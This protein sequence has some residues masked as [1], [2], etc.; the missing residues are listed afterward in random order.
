MFNEIKPRILVID[1]NPVTYKT[2]S[3]ALSSDFN[4]YQTQDIATIS[5][6][7]LQHEIDIVVLSFNHPDILNYVDYVTQIKKSSEVQV[8]LVYGTFDK[9]EKQLSSIIDIS[10]LRPFD[11]DKLKN[12]MKQLLSLTNPKFEIP[13]NKEN[14][15][16]SK[17]SKEVTSWELAIPDVIFEDETNSED[18]LD[19]MLVPGIILEDATM[20]IPKEV[21][22]E[23][24]KV[25]SD[26]IETQ[27]QN[28]KVYPKQND[29]EYPDMLDV[30]NVIIP[31]SAEVEETRT[32][33]TRVS[34][35]SMVKEPVVK[36]NTSGDILGN[37]KD[38]IRS[39][40][41]SD[42]WLPE[43][44]IQEKNNSLDS[45]HFQKKQELQQ[46]L[47]DG[48]SLLKSAELATLRK[49]VLAQLRLDVSSELKL[50]LFKELK[51]SIYLEFEESQKQEIIREIKKTFVKDYLEKLFTSVNKEIKDALLAEVKDHLFEQVKSEVLTSLN[52]SL[53]KLVETTIL[54]SAKAH[55]VNYA[56]KMINEDLMQIRTSI[57]SEQ[58]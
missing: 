27:M 31:K 5:N 44:H 20:I 3:E 53:E 23:K 43:E 41:E 34:M 49:E 52:K 13:M 56:E 18:L 24:A 11:L 8:V 57:D 36:K 26:P 16:M 25:E 51:K 48:D 32:D 4:I 12:Q 33:V 58:Y 40:V 42:Q 47:L 50:E 6:Y 45:V 37:L 22:V 39:E 35:K 21:M 7:I 54:P 38:K 29:L 10:I 14:D 17:L 46:P 2:L 9:I 28:E 30:E 19:D 55:A 15:V 1:D